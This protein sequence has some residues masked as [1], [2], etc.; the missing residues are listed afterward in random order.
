MHILNYI[1]VALMDMKLHAQ[2]QPYTSISFL[3]IKVLKTFLC[4]PDYTRLNLHNQFNRYE[5]AC[6]KSTLYLL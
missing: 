1:I 5:A 3:D 2:N 4:M 6:T